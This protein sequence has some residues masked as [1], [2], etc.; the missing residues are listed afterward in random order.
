MPKPRKE[1]SL[2][3][4]KTAKL[5]DRVEKAKAG[6]G[7]EKVKTQ[8]GRGKLLA[9]ERIDLLVDDESF[10]EIDL[11]VERRHEDTDPVLPADGVITGL[12]RQLATTLLSLDF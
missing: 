12:G 6:G 7:P 5:L 9:R 8:K 11:L 1:P 10:Q 3:S 4:A 2:L